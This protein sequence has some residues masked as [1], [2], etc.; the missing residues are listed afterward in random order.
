MWQ[1]IGQIFQYIAFYGM[2]GFLLYLVW[3]MGRNSERLTQILIEAVRTSVDSVKVIAEANK[4]L[5]EH[6]TR[7]QSET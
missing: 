1:I 4:K 7:Q 6:I 3:R 5:V 2:F